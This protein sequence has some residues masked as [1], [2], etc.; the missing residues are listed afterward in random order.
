MVVVEALTKKED[1][2]AMAAAAGRIAAPLSSPPVHGGRVP[3]T[4]ETASAFAILSEGILDF[5]FSSNK[6]HTGASTR[7]ISPA[8]IKRI[9]GMIHD[10][11][12]SYLERRQH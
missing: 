3:T 11:N 5:G 9:A 4:L 1:T 12:Q 7:S 10:S 2:E 8:A 6:P